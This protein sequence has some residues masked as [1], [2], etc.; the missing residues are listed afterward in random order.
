MEETAR[1]L[2]YGPYVAHSSLQLLF[3][4]VMLMNSLAVCSAGSWPKRSALVGGVALGLLGL[5]VMSGWA[6]NT[7][8]LLH[9]L[10]GAP[11]MTFNAAAIFLLAG[12]GLLAIA[13]EQLRLT[14]ALGITV[15]V[16]A[17]ISGSQMPINAALCFLL[18]GTIVASQAQRGRLRCQPVLEGVAASIVG[19]IGLASFV[20]YFGGM[21]AAYDWGGSVGM[22][23]H[24][25][26]GFLLCGIILLQ[27]AIDHD[28]G[29]SPLGPKWLPIPAAVFVLTVSVV[30]WQAMLH[31][32]PQPDRYHTAVNA[33]LPIGVLRAFVF[34]LFVYFFQQARYQLK[35]ATQAAAEQ[36]HAETELRRLAREDRLTELPNRALLMERLQHTVT[37]AQL[38]Q[39]YDFGFLFL[40]FDRFKFVNDTL[41][42][43]VGDE[44]LR[45]IAGRLKR[46]VQP[47]DS[48]AV[49]VS[50]AT[51]AR[52]G[53]DEFVV[54]LQ[55]TPPQ[56]VMNLVND[57]VAALGEPYH[58]AG[59]EVHSTAS[60]G[61]V[62][63]DAEYRR[64]EEIVRDAD[65]AMY[66]AKRSGKARY[67]VF[68]A[69]M[70]AALRRRLQLENDLWGAIERQELLL[71]YQPVLS[72]STGEIQSVEVIPN[73]HHPSMGE[74]SATEFIAIAEES[75][76]IHSV[77]DWL[78]TAACE[79]MAEWQHDLGTSAPACISLNL[80]HKLFRDPRFVGKVSQILA[81][82][83]L[84]PECLQLEIGESAFAAHEHAAILSAEKLRELGVQLII[85]EFGTG[86][87]S[88]TSVHRLPVDAIKVNRSLLADLESSQ[89]TAALVHA[90]AVLVRNVGMRMVAEGVQTFPQAVALQKLGCGFA[91][92]RF[93]APPLTADEFEQF[94]PCHGGGITRETQGAMTFAHRWS[95]TMVLC[96]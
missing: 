86:S 47:V 78:L 25:A 64:S 31:E 54:L 19:A 1:K 58:L 74:V 16:F 91:Q 73:W 9:V 88:L 38:Q 79:Q 14:A 50:G 41:G 77:S 85:D 75:D 17:A 2:R 40:D 70:R 15:A 63:G 89:D 65:A 76:L 51:A 61:V 7:S 83:A 29:W 57:L 42:H 90:L 52:L 94:A 37:Q 10:P 66:A 67:V 6:T 55:D 48:L 24:A 21:E 35:L 20:G 34:A 11:V 95:D 87:A 33:T 13:H 96:N 53:G 32:S 59:Q 3:G 26:L 80:S 22:S 69:D 45:A 12:A 28:R 62:L 8:W 5:L 82:T 36:Q 81:Q 18:T 44:L 71:T 4:F 27:L 46:V 84:P 68:D 49:V 30:Y 23:V 60:I 92:G 56:Q 72:L 43:R 93:L 39:R